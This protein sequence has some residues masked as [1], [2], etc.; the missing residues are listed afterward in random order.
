MNICFDPDAVSVTIVKA[1]ERGLGLSLVYGLPVSKFLQMFVMD[2]QKKIEKEFPQTYI[3]HLPS[4]LHVTLVRGN[5]S[6]SPLPPINRDLL[7]RIVSDVSKSDNFILNFTTAHLDLAGHVQLNCIAE[8]LELKISEEDFDKM[9]ETA[10]WTLRSNSWLTI[11]YIG[12]NP[13]ALESRKIW[14]GTTSILSEFSLRM[15]FKIPVKRVKLIHFSHTTFKPLSSQHLISI[16]LE[17]KQA[18]N[19]INIEKLFLT[20][21]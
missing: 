1:T 9:R 11:G 8:D 13:N 14:D 7:E 19:K 6:V 18:S 15:P 5:S 20:L 21:V 2:I 3:W 17:C 10:E 16:P 12:R 4:R